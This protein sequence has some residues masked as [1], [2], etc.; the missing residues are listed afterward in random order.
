MTSH[1]KNGVSPYSE[2]ALSM[3]IVRCFACCPEANSEAGWPS[4]FA[5]IPDASLKAGLV[6]FNWPGVRASAC[7]L[8]IKGGIYFNPAGV[9][10][11]YGYPTPQWFVSPGWASQCLK[12][13][14][15]AFKSGIPPLSACAWGRCATGTRHQNDNRF[16]VKH[17]HYI[18]FYGRIV[19]VYWSRR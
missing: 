6:T 13:L 16:Y 8:I 12:G 18:T 1:L 15:P 3:L 14:S 10:A 17:L 9:V 19:M 4:S 7:F 5:S 11:T 2:K